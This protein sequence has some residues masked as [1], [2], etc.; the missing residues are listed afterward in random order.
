MPDVATTETLA[1]QAYSASLAAAQAALEAGDLAGA[2]AIYSDLRD[3]GAEAAAPFLRPAAALT[4]RQN[5]DEADILLEA[6]AEHF[7]DDAAVAVEYARCADARRDVPAALARWDSAWRRFPDHP[8]I[9]LGAAAAM[10]AARQYRAAAAL[11]QQ[12]QRRFPDVPDLCA[13]QARIALARQDFAAAAA[14]WRAMRAQFPDRAD[15]YAGEADALAAAGQHDAAEAVLAEALSRLPEA[16]EPAIAQARLAAARGDW[17]EASRRWGLVREHHPASEDGLLGQ[18]A[19]WRDLGQFDAADAVLTEALVRF[20]DSPAARVAF[21][22]VSDACGDR[23]E[24]VTRWADARARFPAHSGAAVGEIAALAA[25]PRFP[26]AES[27]ARDAMRRFPTHP[28]P[29]QAYAR[30]AQ[31]RQDGSEADLRWA[32][33][34]ARFPWLHRVDAGSDLAADVAPPELAPAAPLAAPM[35][36][37]DAPVR[38][39]IVGF[40]LSYQMSLLLARMRP[41]R[42]RLKVEWINAGMDL[43]AIRTRFPD[44][45]LTGTDIY[46]EESMVGHAATRQGVRAMLPVS[47]DIRT[48]PTSNIRVLWPF[49][50]PDPRL[51]PE[52]P[53]Y[54]GGRYVDPDRIAAALAN[55]ALTDDALFDLYME[56]TEAAP[57]DLPAM[58]A[59]DLE[60]LAMEEKG[61]DIRLAPFVAAH[62]HDEMLFAAPHE[63]C[64]PIVR[65]VARQ[66][67]ATPTLR[68]IGDLETALA[69]LDRLTTGWRAH[70]RALPIHPRVARTLGLAW[71]SPDRQ[72]PQGHS[73]FDF[74]EY[75]IRYMRWSPWLA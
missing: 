45:Q 66:L 24:A 29:A 10:R 34:A 54:N 53:I 55:P 37:G 4:E 51:V 57:L 74:R 69:G 62:F 30:L 49:H 13:E 27:R 22:V 3:A 2:L 58:Y 20:P 71:W 47:A 12:A 60:R 16:P 64:T 65:E 25:A 28:E 18:A 43:D 5:F 7:R 70:N 59:A 41:Y 26:E 46:F 17:A 6:A 44:G 63:R 32:R 35:I 11:L 68:A 36:G 38:V 31:A 1:T 75:F 48:F 42:Q 21:A 72:Y 9:A 14:F 19:L 67:L 61:L 8:A 39:A 40:H 56:T 33:V 23:T 52:P 15:A 50:G 73:S